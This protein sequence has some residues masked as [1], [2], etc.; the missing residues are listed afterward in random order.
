MYIYIY[1]YISS[2]CDFLREN[3]KLISYYFFN[4]FYFNNLIL[5][6]AINIEWY[7]IYYYIYWYVNF[8]SEEVNYS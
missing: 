6:R 5:E 3:K 4:K 1:I 8:T 7:S 2:K